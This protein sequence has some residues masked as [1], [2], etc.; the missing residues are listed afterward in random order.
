MISILPMHSSSVTVPGGRDGHAVSDDGALA[1]ETR[2]P[3]KNGGSDRT[4]PEQRFAA[5]WTS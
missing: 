4:N 3:K 5:A 1:M 2:L